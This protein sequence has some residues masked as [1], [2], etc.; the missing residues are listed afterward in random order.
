[1]LPSVGLADKK[2]EPK[3]HFRD[4]VSVTTGFYKNCKGRIDYKFSDD[5]YSVQGTCKGSLIN[6]HII[7]KYLELSEGCE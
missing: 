4:C 5:E 2:D 7:E 3:F 6:V 1:M